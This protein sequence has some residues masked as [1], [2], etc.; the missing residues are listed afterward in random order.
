LSLDLIKFGDAQSIGTDDALGEEV[1]SSRSHVV[2][3]GVIWTS[4]GT[5]REVAASANNT[6]SS[7]GFA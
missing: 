7:R 4:S 2:P 1:G 6:E 3:Q 5:R